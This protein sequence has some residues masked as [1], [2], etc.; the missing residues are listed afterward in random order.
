MTERHAG[1]GEQACQ[2]SPCRYKA[3]GELIFRDATK[4][5]CCSMHHYIFEVVGEQKFRERFR[6]VDTG[7]VD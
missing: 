6:M 5:R 3:V 7:R 4:L 1:N 2:C